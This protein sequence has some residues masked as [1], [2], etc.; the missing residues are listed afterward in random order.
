MRLQEIAEGS[1]INI[2][3]TKEDLSVNL[4]TEMAFSF[5]DCILVK[6]FI[7]EGTVVNFNAEGLVIELIAIKEGEVP[8]IWKNV[9]ITREEYEGEVYHA[10]RTG[11]VGVRL[12]RRNSFRVFVGERG[13][14]MEV[15]GNKRIDVIVKDMS[16][17]GIGFLV[18]SAQDPHLKNGSHVHITFS[19]DA[20][21]SSFDVVGRV[22]RKVEEE[23][24][25]LYGCILSKTYPQIDRYCAA[26]Q[27]KNGKNKGRKP[28]R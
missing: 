12:N 8:Y 10:V 21:R 11:T 13:C 6:P 3:A 7:Y 1:K 26:K 5:S 18:D 20:M 14:A 27:V 24:K 19:D 16:S 4:S 17:T 22:I 28:K 23:E 25:T 9:T 15:P 2:T